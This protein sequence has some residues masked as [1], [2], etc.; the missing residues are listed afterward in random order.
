MQ[1]LAFAHHDAGPRASRRGGLSRSVMAL[2][3]GLSLLA[4]TALVR[5]Q[6]QQR[7]APDSDI[8]RA[9]G[10]SADYGKSKPTKEAFEKLRSGF[11]AVLN[12]NFVAAT[13][14]FDEAHK[15]DGSLPVG[16]V[17]MALVFSAANRLDLARR[18]LEMAAN[19][20]A[21]SPDVY[22]VLGNLAVREG[23]LTDAMLEYKQA[24]A[25]KKAL[26]ID[27]ASEDAKSF[28]RKLY[29]G[30]TTVAE[31]R[32][33]WD[34]AKLFAELWLA[35]TEPEKGKELTTQDQKDQQA[36]A[37]QRL[38]AAEYFRG[39]AK[40]AEASLTRASTL[41]KDIANPKTQLGFFA[42]Q[43]ANQ[44]AGGDRSNEDYINLMKQAQKY[45][46]EGIASSTGDEA[47][48][49]AEGAYAQWLAQDNK[50][51]EAEE[52][53]NKALGLDPKSDAYKRVVAV[54]DLHRHNFKEAEKYFR[55]MYQKSPSDLFASNNLALALVGLAINLPESNTERA[56]DLR[57]AEELAVVNARANP[58]SAEALS[59][60]A[61]VYVNQNRINEA[62]QLL[63]KVVQGSQQ[64][65]GPDV[66]YYLAKVL[67]RAGD[68]SRAAGMLQRAVQVPGPF[69]Y[70]EEAQTWLNQLLG[71]NVK[72]VTPETTPSTQTSSKS[73]DGAATGGGNAPKSPPSRN[74]QQK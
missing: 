17:Q 22:L 44:K 5:A 60:L 57:M 61:W 7:S 65:I 58:N 37:L 36:A 2:A 74:N 72:P 19:D 38:A 6:Q 33:K 45:F 56:D 48:A 43:E 46:E 69:M 14:K 51:K 8:K 3:L 53:A 13:E 63:S 62:D 50:I 9:L 59:T 66:A 16:E 35:N 30:Q 26:N 67:A 32:R 24:E 34:E 71:Q 10:L 52:H 68:L 64:G 1:P 42:T 15:L 27:P 25:A 21:D 70:R 20:H 4:P 55:E 39:D 11:N 12:G 28:N 47:K 23:R 54:L 29:M 49:R 18:E 41:N 40:A 31:Q 73:N